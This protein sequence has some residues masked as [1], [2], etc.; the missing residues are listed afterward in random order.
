MNTSEIKAILNALFNLLFKVENHEPHFLT[1]E[2]IPDKEDST[3]KAERS[4][5]IEFKNAPTKRNI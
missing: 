2:Y 3:E 1:I 5:S 4:V